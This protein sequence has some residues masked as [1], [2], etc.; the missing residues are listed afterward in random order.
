[1]ILADRIDSIVARGIP[2]ELSSSKLEACDVALTVVSLLAIIDNEVVVCES[3][4]SCLE[5]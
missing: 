3:Q 2:L 5:V 1:L 4:G